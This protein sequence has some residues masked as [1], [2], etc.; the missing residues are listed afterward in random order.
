MNPHQLLSKHKALIFTV[1]ILQAGAIVV[2]WGMVSPQD[3]YPMVISYLISAVTGSIIGFRGDIKAA[4]GVSWR[5]AAGWFLLW[6]IVEFWLTDRTST[7]TVVMI[8]QTF[9]VHALIIGIAFVLS[10][11]VNSIQKSSKLTPLEVIQALGAIAGIVAVVLAIV[12]AEPSDVS[13]TVSAPTNV[14]SA[15]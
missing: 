15:P 2:W 4:F 7:L 12:N 5:I 3:R 10:G 11:M 14:E 13:K 1:A 6:S 8:V 9:L